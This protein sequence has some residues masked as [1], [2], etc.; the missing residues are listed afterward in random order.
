L[1][2]RKSEKNSIEDFIG[3]QK[4][5]EKNKI[6][7]CVHC[8]LLLGIVREG[9][10]IKN[11]EGD[12]DI[13]IDKKYGRRV[14]ELSKELSKVGIYRRVYNRTA[15][16]SKF[17]GVSY[18]NGDTQLHINFSFK[19]DD[20][21]YF[22]YGKI[23]VGPNTNDHELWKFPSHMFD[24]YDYIE[25]GDAKV[26]TPSPIRNYLV[27]RYGDWEKPVRRGEGFTNH[28]KK[29]NPC[30]VVVDTKKLNEIF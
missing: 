5:M 28:S 18:K 25:W 16:K 21:V 3:F 24:E 29:L 8:G 12:I 23:Y 2:M 1:S 15:D 27:A 7:F 4:I 30:L 14:V 17:T 26:P 6:P 20:D 10:F 22:Y 13:A 19:V 11:D 9:G